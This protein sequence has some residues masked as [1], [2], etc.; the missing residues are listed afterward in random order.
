MKKYICYILYTELKVID[1][2]WCQIN[3]RYAKVSK[4]SFPYVQGYKQSCFE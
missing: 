1:N 4:V 3:A 2:H